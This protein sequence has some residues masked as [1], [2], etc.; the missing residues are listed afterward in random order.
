M[1]R[2]RKIKNIDQKLATH[3]KYLVESPMEN[4]GKWNRVFNNENPI[5]A[6]FGCGRGQ[7]II[8]KASLDPDSN[9]I[10]FESRGSIIIRAL[11][12]AIIAD[13]NNTLFVNENVIDVNEYFDQGELAG[14]YLNFSDPWPKKGYAKRRLTHR[15]FLEGYKKALRPGGYIEFKTDNIDLFAFTLDE[16]R[17][18]NLNIIEVT[19]DLHSTDLDARLVTTEYEDKFHLWGKKISYLKIQV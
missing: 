17:E 12:K 5:Y 14:I 4:R 7:F 3:T 2:Q 11:E 10:G 1:L 19:D 16:C 15:R 8:K 13:K 18:S 9:Y 6:E